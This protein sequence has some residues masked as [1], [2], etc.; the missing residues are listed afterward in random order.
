[1]S[2]RIFRESSGVAA[3]MPC[4][5]FSKSNSCLGWFCS[6]FVS[7][8]ISLPVIIFPSFLSLCLLNHNHVPNAETCTR[9]LKLVF[10]T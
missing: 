9:R 2:H 3:R 8:A 4:A 7:F 10:Q 5:S 1:M 6:D